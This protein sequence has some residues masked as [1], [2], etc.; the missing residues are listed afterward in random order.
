MIYVD[1]LKMDSE[2]DNENVN[3]PSFP[4][5]EP[6]ISYID[7]LDLLKDI[8]NEFPAIVY[9]ECYSILLYVLYGVPFDPKQYYK[10]GVYT[11]MLRRPRSSYDIWIFHLGL[12]GIGTLDMRDYNRLML[13]LWILRLGLTG[14]MLIEHRDAHG[15]IMFTSRDWRRLFDIRGPLVHELILE[16]FSTFRFGKAV[17]EL[18]T[19]GALQFQLDFRYG[20]LSAYW[21]GISS[22]WDFLGTSPSYTLI[23]DL[24][25]RLC[26]RLIACSIAERSQAPEKDRL[27]GLTVIAPTLPV[28]YM[29]ELVRLQICKN[30]DDTWAWVAPGPERQQVST[31]GT[32]EAVEDVPIVNEGAQAIP[33]PV[34]APQPPLAARSMPQRMSIIEEDVREIRGALGEQREVVDVMARDFS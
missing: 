33:A 32:H 16:F 28:I 5:L 2:N 12:K 17:L 23:M 18:D 30:I 20:G 22:A 7:D 6:M 14:R 21:I 4:P 24:I 9:N 25:L 13:I 1:K 15:H 10:D 3:A 29:A 8:K 34:Q 31:T 19:A 11:R 26:H 27:L